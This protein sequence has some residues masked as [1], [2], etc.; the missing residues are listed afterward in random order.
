MLRIFL[1][2]LDSRWQMILRCHIN[3]ECRSDLHV[4]RCYY[5][6][7]DVEGNQVEDLG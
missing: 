6:E 2:F 1:V 7:Q 4:S 5:G 3:N